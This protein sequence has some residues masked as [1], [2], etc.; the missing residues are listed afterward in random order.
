M[1]FSLLTYHLMLPMLEYFRHVFGNYGWAIILVTV[2]IK[3]A[4]TPLSIKQL[5]SSQKMQAQMAKIKP[6][7]DHI[8][9]K[10]N[11]RK[12]KYESNPQK[13]EEIQR[14]FQDQMTALYRGNGAMNPLS[15]CL[16]T[17]L[18]F[19]LL[20]A[21]YWT[22]SGPP[23]QA[24]ILHAPLKASAEAS[25][26]NSLSLKKVS[27][28][29]VNFVDDNGKT[30]RL[31]L[32]SN[33]PEKLM[34][35]QPYE[36][37]LKQLSGKA[38]LP[39][40]GIQWNLLAK[41]QNPQLANQTYK[42]NSWAKGIV[43]LKVSETDPTKATITALKPTERFTLQVQVPEARG[44][45]GFFFIKD[46]GRLGINNKATGELHWDI[47]VL[48]LLMGA[49]FWISN[50]VMMNNTPQPPSL[51]KSQQ[52][53]QKQM[54]NIMPIMFLGMMAFFPIPAGVFIYFIVSNVFQLAQSLYVKK[55]SLPPQVEPKI[56]EITS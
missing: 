33:I 12:K 20:I 36:L 55:F 11:Q 30:A 31:K 49:S 16:P 10:Y 40:E 50:K 2:V 17:L 52:D 56:S 13:L 45:E 28:S 25:T 4:L 22:F 9:E 24:S 27:S 54:Q 15:G 35:G 44:H 47:I 19:P 3:V 23:F 32:E 5:E 41:G 29:S 26:K 53:M 14:E 48:I 51:D 21:L 39:K 43:D 7:L 34:V 37:T 38:V 18:Q 46:L 8:Q 6:E 1:D 42:N